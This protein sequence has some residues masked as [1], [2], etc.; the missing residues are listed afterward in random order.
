MNAQ[1]CWRFGTSHSSCHN[2][3]PPSSSLLHLPSRAMKVSRVGSYSTPLTP[4]Q[5]ARD[6]GSNRAACQTAP[7]L[8]ESARGH[9]NPTTH[10]IEI[11]TGGSHR[12]ST[13]KSFTTQPT[14][15]CLDLVRQAWR[16]GS[17]H[18]SNHHNAPAHSLTPLMLVS[19][20]CSP[21]PH[22]PSLALCFII[23]SPPLFNTPAH[24][25]TRA[26]DRPR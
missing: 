6:V 25:Q 15:W 21:R 23:S 2:P 4:T 8:D 3:P 13:A 1:L 19:P 26:I 10:L 9:H 18:R 14:R 22:H 12:H 24:A 11:I 17:T 5:G 7:A 20:A 16:L